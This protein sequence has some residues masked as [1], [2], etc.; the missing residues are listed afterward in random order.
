LDAGKD[1]HSISRRD[2]KQRRQASHLLIRQCQ[3]LRDIAQNMAR[4]IPEAMLAA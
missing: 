2:A 4:A 1:N 3:K